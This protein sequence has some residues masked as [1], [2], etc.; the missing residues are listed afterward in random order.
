MP[1][2]TP[3][4]HTAR[5]LLRPLTEADT[6]PI[7]ALH[8]DPG[9]SRYW[10]SP[11]WRQNAQAVNFIALCK[12]MERERRGAAMA[13]QRAADGV[14]IGYCNLFD[15]NPIHRSVKLGYCLHVGAWG[16]GFA[17]EA[18]RGLLEW[19]FSALDLNRVQAET[20]PRNTA[21]NRVLEKLGF[22]HEGTLREDC[23]VGGEIS[24]SRVYGLLRR[25]WK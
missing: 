16:Q 19:G 3:T 15:W 4:L 8:S 2:P 24:D 14:F 11:P 9:V 21:S 1:F 13:L 6:L 12:E 17:P 18:A 22:T 25:E 5:L 23:I 10:N 20:D 7:F